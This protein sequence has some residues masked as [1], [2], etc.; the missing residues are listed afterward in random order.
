MVVTGHSAE[1][2]VQLPCTTHPPAPLPKFALHCYHHMSCAKYIL[3]L[4]V[5]VCNFLFYFVIQNSIIMNLS[6]HPLPLIEMNSIIAQYPL[7]LLMMLL[8]SPF[9]IITTAAI[10]IIIH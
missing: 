2:L 7:D 8:I 3:L 9:H 6:F 10:I 1:D 5:W 4:L